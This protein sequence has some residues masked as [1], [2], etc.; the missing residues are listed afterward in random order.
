MGAI[1]TIAHDACYLL[2]ATDSCLFTLLVLE[3]GRID[4]GNVI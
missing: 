4:L 3:R 1:I 2:I